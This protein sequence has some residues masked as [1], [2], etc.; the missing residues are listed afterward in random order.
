LLLVLSV[1]RGVCAGRV[2]RPVPQ[3]EGKKVPPPLPLDEWKSWTYAE[4]F[5]DAKTAA[6]ALISLGFNQFDSVTIW[7]NNAPEW[8]LSDLAAILAA[9]KAAGIYPTDTMEQVVFKCTHSG[10]K[11]VFIEDNGK[12]KKFEAMVDNLPNLLAIVVWSE[13]PAATSLPRKGSGAAVDVL[14][15]AD[16][17]G[18]AAGVDDAALEARMDAQDPGHCCGLVWPLHL[19][20]AASLWLH[21]VPVRALLLWLSVVFASRPCAVLCARSTRREPLATRRP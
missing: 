20:L 11:V 7:G 14:S 15:W 1:C 9:G 19:L 13:A 5:A 12:L 3:M 6:K 8:F 17:V 16:F 2:E 4:Y 18:K 21:R 10:S